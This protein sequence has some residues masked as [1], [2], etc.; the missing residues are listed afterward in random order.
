MSTL[1]THQMLITLLKKWITFF[2]W[3]FEKPILTTFSDKI[4]YNFLKFANFLRF[5]TEL[6]T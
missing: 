1:A 4:F 6:S 3:F 2:K 5:S